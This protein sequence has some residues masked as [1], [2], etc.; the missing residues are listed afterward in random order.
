MHVFKLP[1][2]PDQLR[3]AW[4]RALHREDIEDLK[5]VNVCVKHFREGDIEY[6]HKVPNGDGTYR[7]IPRSHLKL[8]E[9]SVPAL[10]PGCPAY[11]SSSSATKR[12]RLSFE[13]K[14]DELLN[15]ALNLSFSLEINENEN[16]LIKHFQD[17]QDKSPS[18]SLSKI[19]SICYPNER[20]L[21]FMRPGFDNKVTIQVDECSI[22]EFDLSIKACQKGEILPLSKNFLR[23]NWKRF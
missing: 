18:L 22:V 20:I 10:L 15:Q 19:W 13:S 14:D 16:F 17:L 9:D 7:E 1:L 11:Y 3:H 6:T 21:V 2:K 4:L 5:V 23:D 12:S 8:K